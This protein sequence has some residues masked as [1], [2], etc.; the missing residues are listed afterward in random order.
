MTVVIIPC[1][2]SK[3]PDPARA[4]ELYIGAYFTANLTWA[5]SIVPD[6]R[7]FILSALHGLVEL[8]QVLNPY[9]LK[10]GQPG[11]V[12]ASK[13]RDQANALCLHMA[14]VYA[15]GGGEYL[16]KLKAAGLMFCAPAAGLPM[17]KQMQILKRNRGAVPRWR[18]F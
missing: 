7:I 4:A 18:E 6:H 1:G 15:L 13:V 2:S 12:E 9:N 11:S 16:S 8:H 3:L 5:R 14:K 10:M 17:G